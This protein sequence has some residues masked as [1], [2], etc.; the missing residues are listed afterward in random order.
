MGIRQDEAF[1]IDFEKS[2]Q[3]KQLLTEIFNGFQKN[4]SLNRLINEL[5]PLSVILN[6]YKERV[7]LVLEGHRASDFCA[8]YMD[9]NLSSTSLNTVNALRRLMEMPNTILINNEKGLNFEDLVDFLYYRTINARGF[10][11]R[12]QV[13][14]VF[15]LYVN[16]AYSTPEE[17]SEIC[18]R[19]PFLLEN[20]PS[21][22]YVNISCVNNAK[23]EDYTIKKSIFD[24]LLEKNMIAQNKPIIIDRSGSN[25]KY[26]EKEEI[27]GQ[28]LWGLYRE[29]SWIISQTDVPKATLG[30]VAEMVERPDNSL[31]TVFSKIFKNKNHE[32]LSLEF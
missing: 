19:H 3:S 11:S 10:L 13:D 27:Y 20:H 15:K 30:K 31:K 14:E 1:S 12:E 18:E 22:K 4:S 32:N 24:F 17:L 21:F 6:R 2:D 25:I 9:L 16:A 26:T 23:I 29:D 5:R 8:T 28:W 7:D